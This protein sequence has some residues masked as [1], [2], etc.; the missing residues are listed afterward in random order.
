MKTEAVARQ[1]LHRFK[2]WLQRRVALL[3]QSGAVWIGLESL[4]AGLHLG[5]VQKAVHQIGHAAELPFLPSDLHHQAGLPEGLQQVFE[6]RHH[7]QC[8]LVPA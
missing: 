5:G 6:A 4:E 1:F 8:L 3:Q 2:I 7:G